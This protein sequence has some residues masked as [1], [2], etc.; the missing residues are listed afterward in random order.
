MWRGSGAPRYRLRASF[1]HGWSMWGAAVHKLLAEL[2]PNFVSC[3]LPAGCAQPELPLH[4]HLRQA[5][6]DCGD[7]S[8]GHA[9]P[10]LDSGICEPCGLVGCQLC[11]STTSC[12]QCFPGFVL[13]DERCAFYL[14]SNGV[15][16]SVLQGLSVLLAFLLLVVFICYCYGKRSR[17]AEI[18]LQ[19]M[20]EAR[21]HRHLCKLHR[22]EMEAAIGNP[23]P[24]LILA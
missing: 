15:S 20:V 11:T 9:L 6:G 16:A 23:E 3:F 12:A 22:W 8:P 14:D 10:N 1:H 7:F 4:F 24:G 17:F 5:G 13:Q 18:N 21:R 19:H 2:R